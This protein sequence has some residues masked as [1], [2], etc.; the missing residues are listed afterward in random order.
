MNNERMNWIEHPE[1][2]DSNVGP[3]VRATSALSQR[4]RL[5]EGLR[6]RGQFSLRER[7][8]E[9]YHILPTNPIAA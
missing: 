2:V 8:R 1:R 3:L 6:A 7:E 9:R 5:E 4:T